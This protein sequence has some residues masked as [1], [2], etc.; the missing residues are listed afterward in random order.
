[1]KNI[2]IGIPVK[3]T[4]KYLDNL[5]SQINKLDY[6]LK[7]ITI[8][9]LE[10]DSTDNTYDLCREVTFKYAPL[11]RNVILHKLDFG[12]DLPHNFDRYDQQKFPN[13]IKNLVISRNFIIDNYTNDND[14]VWWIDSDFEIIPS[15]TLLKFIECDKDIVI[16]VLTHDKWGFHDCGSVIIDN[17]GKQHRFQCIET[18]SNLIKLSRADTHCFIKSDVFKKLKY[19]YVPEMYYDGCGGVQHCWSDGTYFSLEAVKLGFSLYG[20]R[21]IVI[22]HHNV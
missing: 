3:N 4:G 12:F 13:R 20:A 2:L 1:M 16:P 8:V 11:F 10:S 6:D 7:K 22:K 14:Y 17:D 15:D 19:K 9:M 18:D 5:F 21:H